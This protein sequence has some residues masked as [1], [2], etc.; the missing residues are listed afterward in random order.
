VFDSERMVRL[1]VVTLAVLFLPKTIGLFRALLLPEL[2]RGCGGG[3]RL[4]G[5]AVAELLLSALYAPI[6]LVI[7]SR[8]VYEILTGRDSGWGPQRR[9]HG[10]T[11]WI[12]AWRRHRWH[13]ACGLGIAIVAWLISPMILA[14]LSPTLV[15]MLL[16]VPLSKLSGSARAGAALRRAGLLVT[17]EETRPPEILVEH[18][19]LPSRRER[20]QGDGVL[21]LA[22][23]PAM[24]ES[25]YRWAS[26]APRRRGAPDPAY[27]TAI[28]KIAE[29]ETRDEALAW[30]DPRERVH[31]AGHR[32]LLE[33]MLRLPFANEVS[34][35]PLPFPM[36]EPEPVPHEAPAE[37]RVAVG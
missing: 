3:L 9:D 11:L 24:R 31:V 25:H 36:V 19:A 14:W 8:H 33:Q 20:F 15:G 21:A 28:Q 37:R 34:E 5:S 32:P 29:A 1:F 26:P 7:H 22:T 6:M 30:L 27:L 17:P 16:A 35:E 13:M 23:D 12:D 4:I 10:E 18:A 2:R